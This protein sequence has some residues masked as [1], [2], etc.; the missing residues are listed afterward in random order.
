MKRWS[1]SPKSLLR[2]TPKIT[3]VNGWPYTTTASSTQHHKRVAFEQSSY[4]IYSCLYFV[5]SYKK[6]NTG[7][8]QKVCVRKSIQSSENYFLQVVICS[9]VKFCR[10]NGIFNGHLFIRVLV[11]AINHSI[12]RNRWFLISQ[13][14][15]VAVENNPNEDIESWK[16]NEEEIEL[17]NLEYKLQNITPVKI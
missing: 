15:V 14:S 12:Y 16:K 5:K 9:W 11:C 3:V 1:L 6:T 7:T 4:F 10:V 17:C 8:T 2:R 13:L